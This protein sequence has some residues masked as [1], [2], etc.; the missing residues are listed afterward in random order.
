MRGRLRPAR[1]R[2]AAGALVALAALAAGPASAMRGADGR[3]NIVYWQT[4]AT[5]NP[6]LATGTADID[7]AG[8]ALEA[9]ARFDDK[10]AITPYLAAEIPTAENGGVA[11]DRKSI[12][13]RLKPD[14]RW[15]DGSP[16]TAHDAVFTWEYCTHPDFGCAQESYLDSVAGMV[17][18]NDHTLKIS[19]DGPKSVPHMALVGAE[20]PILQKRQFADCLGAAAP[21]CT[22]QN[23]R[24]N[25]TG[26]FRVVEFAPH[27]TVLFEANPH[28]REPEKPAFASVLFKSGGDAESAARAVLRTGEFDYAWNLQIP[29]AILTEM[30]AAGQGEVLVAFG[31]AVERIHVNFT[32]PDPRLGPDLR[33]VRL[34]DGSNRHPILHDRRV[35]RALARAIDT[36]ALVEI[37]YGR[38]GKPTCNLIPGP[39]IYVSRANDECLTRNPEEARQLL[40]E[41]GWIPGPDGVRAKDGRRLALLFTSTTNTIRQEAQSLIKSWWEAI[42]VEVEL[43]AVPSGVFFGGDPASPDT[44]ARFYA[45]LSMY[46]SNFA[47]VDP[48]AYLASWTC[49]KTPLPENQWRGEN[50]NRWCDADYDALAAQLAQTAG[51]AAR[52]GIVR[53]MNDMLVGE[54]VVIPLVHRSLTSA[55][56]GALEGVRLN[57]WDTGL[58]N[59]ADW[60]RAR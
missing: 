53:R 12:T 49:E 32:D 6:Y 54:Y 13:W 50:I 7:A 37:G 47:G 1:R 11:A 8:L 35:R 44:H 14:V 34:A 21:A 55:R 56:S 42:G 25:G 36:E 58:W 18:L 28:Y 22:A 29:P 57:A 60:R 51:E 45:D 59:I 39:D 38:T 41:A 9:L 40:D 4:V 33:S 3:L 17:A 52:A 30:E 15:S 31:A 5:M 24:P 23:F 19:F 43:R 27:D 2:A 48:E 10:G 16:F 26:P 46:T 20:A